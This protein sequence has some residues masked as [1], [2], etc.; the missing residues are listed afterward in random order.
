MGAILSEQQIKEIHSFL[1]STE[2][3]VNR[4]LQNLLLTQGNVPLDERYISDTPLN[5]NLEGKNL[6]V[7]SDMYLILRAKGIISKEDAEKAKS[8]LFNVYFPVMRNYIRGLMKNTE[9]AQYYNSNSKYGCAGDGCFYIVWDT[10][11]SVV[12]KIKLLRSPSV[13][14]IFL[15]V[16]E[17][18]T[19]LIVAHTYNRSKYQMKV[20]DV[21]IKEF[22]RIRKYAAQNGLELSNLN[23]RTVRP[24]LK[25]NQGESIFNDF[26]SGKL[27]VHSMEKLSDENDG[28][29]DTVI[30]P[31]S[32]SGHAIN[33][34]TK[35]N[36]ILYKSL[37]SL[38]CDSET[39]NEQARDL[40]VVFDTIIEND[41]DT[42]E[43]EK[44]IKTFGTECIN[45]S[46]VKLARNRGCEMILEYAQKHYS[47]EVAIEQRDRNK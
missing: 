22:N 15:K 34:G 32:T 14:S 2:G 41:M 40:V 33:A 37:L 13:R 44:M 18:E 11:T 17:H 25:L 36:N 30:K 42:K 28:N 3:S 6:P 26:I 12:H 45:K 46:F 29:L 4:E 23:Y 47:D 5:L 43:Y 8:M 19:Q 39:T 21:Y 31:A 1:I 16:W 38:L 24:I 20:A 7:Q 9:Y 27:E 35:N 10:F